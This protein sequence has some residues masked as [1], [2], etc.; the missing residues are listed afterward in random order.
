M[1]DFTRSAG[2]HPSARSRYF[3]GGGQ[4]SPPTDRDVRAWR[5][6]ILHLDDLGFPPLGVPIDVLLELYPEA[7]IVCDAASTRCGAP[8][9]GQ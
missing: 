9:D 4:Y 5:D 1:T 2:N 7:M 3:L 8:H 6:T